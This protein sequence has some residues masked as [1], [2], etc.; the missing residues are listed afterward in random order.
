MNNGGIFLQ[1]SQSK[2]YIEYNKKAGQVQRGLSI[3]PN[4]KHTKLTNIQPLP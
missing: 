2:N 3:N 4:L 1:V